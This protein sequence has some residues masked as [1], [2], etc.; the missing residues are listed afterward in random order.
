MRV[1]AVIFDLWD[2]LVLW[3]L[4][5]A[6]R[7]N[8]QI[9]ERLGVEL[10]RFT[11]VWNAA[12]PARS[13]GPLVENVR[14]VLGEL[15]VNGADAE[16]IAALRIDHTRRVLRPREGAL[17]TLEEL[18]RRGLRLGLISVCGEDV[19]HAWEKTPFAPLLDSVVLSCTVG[20][21]KPDP[22]IYELAAEELDVLPEECLF[23]GD[24]ANDEVAGAERA[25]MR[26]ALILRPGGEEPLW[27]E[28]RA[29]RGPRLRALPEV[30]A[31]LA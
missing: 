12:R 6:A 5:E 23:V 16:E 20:L 7:L 19:A 31:L 28:A 18:R 14:Q 25:G 3:P 30:L 13:V 26:A 10:E 11:A 15:G 27:P 24:G 17:E 4:D 2:T 21:S 9:A 8:E 22:R 29:W 1:R